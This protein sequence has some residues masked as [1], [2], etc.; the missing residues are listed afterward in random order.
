MAHAHETILEI[1]LDAL[2]HNFQYLKSKIDPDTRI[3]G[4]VK[5]F[6]Y[7][8]DAIEVA[9]ELVTQGVDYFAV[10]YVKEGVALRDAGIETP[11]LVLHP[12]PN[13][14]EALIDRCLEPALYSARILRAFIVTAESKSQ[15]NYPVHIKFNTGLN[16]LGFWEND[17]DWIM[18]RLG[19][20]SSVKVTSLFSHLA[21]SEDLSERDFTL[22]QIGSFKRTAKEMIGKLG[23]APWLHQSNTSAILNY[24]EAQFDLVRTGIGLYGYGN[25]EEEDK[26]LR[27]VARL[28]SVI[29]QI[30]RIEPGET[31][32]YNR[33]YT[34]AHYEQTATLPI[35]HADGISRQLGNGKGM[36][37]IH[38]KQAPIIG[39]VCMDMLMVNITGIDCKEGDEVELI[40]EIQS[41]VQLAERMG[42]IS[43]ELLTALSQRVKRVVRRKQ[44]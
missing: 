10:A 19:E 7:G 27:P 12:Q 34:A 23:Y 43:Y 29:S 20:T 26:K 33:A 9:K 3:M 15:T 25:S 40:G 28:K 21:A 6:G 16:R 42:S 32:G 4:V 17:V 38:G 5:A 31:V 8:S 44:P 24:P 41:A 37:S 11:I 39:N 18:E 36:V 14:F 22:G 35:G 1:D 13:N 2:A 30:H